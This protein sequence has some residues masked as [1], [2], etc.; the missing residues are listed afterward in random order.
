M[1]RPVARMTAARR[2]LLPRRPAA[3]RP[4]SRN[5]PAGSASARDDLAFEAEA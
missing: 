1:K 3:A 5:P 4:S 2:D